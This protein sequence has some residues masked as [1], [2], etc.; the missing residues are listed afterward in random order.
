MPCASGHAAATVTGTF[1]T[2]GHDIELC[3]ACSLRIVMQAQ[4]EVIARA[5]HS[6]RHAQM[7]SKS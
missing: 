5:A 6:A 4:D 2:E 7:G 3:A 1:R